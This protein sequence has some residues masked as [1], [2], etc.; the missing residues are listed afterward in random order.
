MKRK[1]FI[2]GLVLMFACS[3]FALAEELPQPTEDPVLVEEPADTPDLPAEDAEPQEEPVEIPTEDPVEEPAEEPIEEPVSL[4][5]LLA[6]LAEQGLD[7]AALSQVEAA[8]LQFDLEDKL[9]EKTAV[10]KEIIVETAGS[11]AKPQELAK[12]TLAAAENLARGVDPDAL[13]VAIQTGAE[14]KVSFSFL[15]QVMGQ[16]PLEGEIEAEGDLSSE[17][18]L[19]ADGVLQGTIAGNKMEQAFEKLWEL[20]PLEAEDVLAQVESIAGQ[21]GGKINKPTFARLVDALS[22]GE[23]PALVGEEI[24]KELEQNGGKISQLGK[25]KNQGK[26]EKK[27][28]EEIKER[29]EEKKNTPNEK[30]KDKVREELREELQERLEEKLGQGFQ[31]EKG[32]KP[33]GDP[34]DAPQKGQGKGK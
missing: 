22:A 5:K 14:V 24:R 2:L 31:K 18:L 13:L 33:E 8:L 23:D 21:V 19:T 28:W 9:G 11:G 4:D 20:D 27:V 16:L 3:T 29:I 6:D 34:I 12:L 10:L 1:L 25:E 15:A 32:N 17:F 30:Q 26:G 7:E